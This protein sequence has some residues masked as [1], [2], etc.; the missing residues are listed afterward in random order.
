MSCF[1]PHRS[2]YE[3]G[4]KKIKI[5]AQDVFSEDKGSYTGEVSPLMLKN[6][7]CEYVIIGHSERKRYFAE[8]NQ[9]IN[10]K[11]INALRNGLK[12]ILCVGESAEQKTNGAAV[13][14]RQLEE[15]LDG[16]NKAKIENVT[17]CY[18]PVWAISSNHPDHPPTC[19]EIMGAGLLIRK[20]LVG[21]YG[22]KTAEKV[23]II[24][25]GSVAPDNVNDTCINSGMKGALVGKESLTPHSFVK[26][27]EVINN[28]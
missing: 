4:Q 6:F 24:Y 7:G 13:V 21:K 20:F 16:I 8:N 9:E 23:R 5:G 3:M 17:I 27:A 12:P 14:M 25:G 10:L 2:F 18:E 11:I 15:C 26:V 19:N 1:Y 28:C 22:A